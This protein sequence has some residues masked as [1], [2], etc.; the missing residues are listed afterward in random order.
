VDHLKVF[1]VGCALCLGTI[2]GSAQP[3]VVGWGDNTYGQ[4]SP[5]A[6]L[7]NVM[8]I[9]AGDHHSLAL[10]SNGIVAAWGDDTDGKTDVPPG[11]SNVVAIA[12]GSYHSLA[13]KRDG[14]VVAWGVSQGFFGYYGQTRVPFWLSDVVAIA[15]GD[16]HS[17]ALRRDGTVVA[18]GNND[19]GQTNVP[20]GLFNV[21]GVAG[22]LYHSLA[23][24]KDGTV[25]GWGSDVYGQT[26]GPAGSSN[27]A[28]I[29]ARQ[30]FSMV[31][32]S[33]GTVVAWGYNGYGQAN[34]PAGLSNVVAI[35]TSGD[36]SLALRNNGTVVAWG[37]NFEGETNVP[38]GLFN[39]VSVAA[40]GDSSLALGNLPLA[41]FCPGSLTVTGL[42]NVP[43]PNP[44]AVFFYNGCGGVVVSHLGDSS[45]SSGC[46]NTILRTYQ[47]VD[48]CHSTIIC[49]QTITV[50]NPPV[51]VGFFQSVTP[52][53]GGLQV[54]VYSILSGDP[55]S[56]YQ[57]FSNGVARP[58]SIDHLSLLHGALD[59]SDLVVGLTVSNGCGNGGN[60][61]PVTTCAI[62]LGRGA[63]SLLEGTNGSGIGPTFRTT[64]CVTASNCGMVSS[65]SKWFKMIAT[66]ET[67][68]VTISTEGSLNQPLLA[69]Y[70]GPLD[71]SYLIPVC[72]DTSTGSH[73]SRVTFNAV[74]G[75]VYWIVVDPHTNNP[76]L[77]LAT[78]F[79]PYLNYNYNRTSRWFEVSS[80]NP[81]AVTYRL[82][83]TT[84]FVARTSDLLVT[85]TGTNWQ[86]MATTNLGTNHAS[87]Y[88]R[89]TNAQNLKQR[90]YRLAA[91]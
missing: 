86:T 68:S 9:A 74:K 44:G 72:C 75:S 8:A 34:V 82:L 2:L 76:T 22:G 54:D 38:A 53:P 70:T 33:N 20:A 80:T 56:T 27:V 57:W 10:M 26:T 16:L 14:T 11:L 89:D 18:W 3:V 55:P 73:A 50:L 36:H 17:L 83:A 25:V 66:N 46:T 42:V 62:C 37:Y 47:A 84:S 64:N 7:T 23:L 63:P 31:L 6:S 60:S 69:V 87:V 19:V 39:T 49:T 40:G 1:S 90:F 48:S 24:K 59:D 45:N 41:I 35:A 88:Y 61:T 32:K 28:A 51:V 85:Y 77:Q 13:L 29:A 52:V 71:P 67:G 4:V 79:E 43:P 65:T 81:P 5:P 91:P 21:V 30:Y 58:G 15:A 78:G 12:A